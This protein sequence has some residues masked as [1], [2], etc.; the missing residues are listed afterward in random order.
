[1]ATFLQGGTFGL[2]SEAH[3][4]GSN[5]EQHVFKSDQGCGNRQGVPTATIQGNLA[6]PC[7]CFGNNGTSVPSTFSSGVS[8]QNAQRPAGL[9][10]I[11]W[12]QN[13]QDVASSIASTCVMFPANDLRLISEEMYAEIVVPS[14]D[15]SPQGNK[16]ADRVTNSKPF[17]SVNY[18]AFPASVQP[19]SIVWTDES[20]FYM[21]ANNSCSGGPCNHYV[22]T[23]SLNILSIGCSSVLCNNT[24]PFNQLY[25]GRWW[26]YVCVYNELFGTS[27]TR[28]F[29]A[30]DCP[31]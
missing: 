8:G 24:S 29:P 9:S 16:V 21:C 13:L 12:N 10:P 30:V 27:F 6:C 11:Y 15:F 5:L 1:L 31:A 20:R 19:T 26:F 4:K 7:N 3:A 23:S 14:A 18:A 2:S 28:P 25:P 17:I 22:V